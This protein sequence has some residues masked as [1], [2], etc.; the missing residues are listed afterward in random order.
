MAAA[1]AAFG[2]GRAFGQSLT[3]DASSANPGAPVDGSGSWNTVASNWTDGV[4]V[5]YQTWLDPRAS[6]EDLSV[7]LMADGATV[8]SVAWEHAKRERS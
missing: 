3:W 6:L 8:K 7:Q 2:G 4:T 5:K 1:A